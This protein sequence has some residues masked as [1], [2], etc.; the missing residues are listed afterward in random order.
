VSSP[1]AA[2]RPDSPPPPP[3]GRPPALSR[4]ARLKC[5][6]LVASGVLTGRQ[7]AKL[8]GVGKTTVYRW[9]DAMLEEP[10]PDG[11]LLRRLARR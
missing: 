9:A 11:D 10:G 5:V 4:E 7:V 2:F 1:R 8:Y 3:P 6:R